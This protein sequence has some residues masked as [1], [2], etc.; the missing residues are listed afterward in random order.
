MKRNVRLIILLSLVVAHPACS[1]PVSY[2]ADPIEASVID[3]ETKRPLEGVIVVAYWQLMGGMEGGIPKGQMNIMETMTDVNG[4][5]HFL[6]WG[7][8]RHFGEGKL[9]YSDPHLIIFK[10]GYDYRFLFN[11]PSV[12]LAYSGKSEWNGKTI[13]LKLFKGEMKKYVQL[14]DSLNSKLEQI[15]GPNPEDCDWKKIPEAIMAT[16]RERKKILAQTLGQKGVDPRTVGS[17]YQDILRNNDWY[18]KKGG[19]GC[20]SPKEYFQRYQR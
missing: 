8:K 7:P 18:T 6:G 14:V 12:T 11:E 19:H 1:K 10:S 20:G 13:E 16:E 4:R 2:S 3:A 9:R 5:F 15:I 17:L